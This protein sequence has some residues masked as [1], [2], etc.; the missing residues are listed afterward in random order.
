MM[1]LHDKHPEKELI[2]F[3]GKILFEIKSKSS[4]YGSYQPYPK[5][6]AKIIFNETCPAYQDCLPA[7]A[8]HKVNL[9]T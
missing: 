9:S 5:E 4:H 3:K 1:K 2:E 7:L 6:Y 8:S